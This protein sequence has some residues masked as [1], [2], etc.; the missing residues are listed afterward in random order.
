MNFFEHIDKSN[1]S[2]LLEQTIQSLEE[3]YGI[4]ILIHDHKGILSLPDGG[5]ILPNRNRHSSP[6]CAGRESKEWEDCVKYCKFEVM[7]RSA[8]RNIP[9]QSICW[10]GL[11]EVIV[12]VYRGSTHLAT[13]FG[14]TFRLP[15]HVAAHYRGQLM[16]D[17]RE[18]YQAMPLWDD[19]RGRK[20]ALLL[21]IVAGGILQLADRLYEESLNDSGRA[22]LIKRFLNLHADKDI[23]LHDLAQHLGLSK[24]RAGHLIKECFDCNF[25]AM[26]NQ[27]RVRRAKSLLEE[28][29]MSLAEI[30]EQV[31]YT[32]EFYFNRIFKKVTGKT[33][34]L[35]RREKISL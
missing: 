13:L 28:S 27:E 20:I 29:S 8:E 2:G 15:D 23:R 6:C 5:N 24:S 32:N 14:G 11:S 30:A 31:G 34:G 10:R 4:R 17:L 19:D 25:T 16:P 18:S 22:R 26:L 21:Q 9:W 7:R 12:P 1:V 35:F 33:P 3:A